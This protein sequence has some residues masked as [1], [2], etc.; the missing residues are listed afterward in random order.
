ML[1]LPY[2]INSRGDTVFY[3]DKKYHNPKLFKQPT[4]LDGTQ[5]TKLNNTLSLLLV[6]TPPHT[7]YKHTLNTLKKLNIK[8]L[9]NY[10]P[11]LEFIN[12]NN[13]TRL[14]FELKAFK[15]KLSLYTTITINYPK[16]TK[17]Q[18]HKKDYNSKINFVIIPKGTTIYKAM[19]YTPYNTNNNRNPRALSSGWFGNLETAKKYAFQANQPLKAKRIEPS[20]PEY[21]RV[22]AFKFTKSAKLFYLMDF[23][24]L[25]TIV[26]KLKS[27]ISTILDR[28]TTQYDTPKHV[29]NLNIS[30]ITKTT[31]NIKIVKML[32]GFQTSYRQQLNLIKDIHP[33]F[34]RKIVQSE[35]Q[36]LNNFFNHEKKN[37]T[38]RV[39]YKIDKNYHS[40]LSYDLN[41]ISMG[42][43]LDRSL[44]KILQKT[45][46]FDG[47]INHRVPSMWE[48]GRYGHNPNSNK[49]PTLDEEI[50]LFVQRG[51][52]KRNRSDPHDDRIFL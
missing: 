46:P 37:R 32:T 48:F 14:T 34:K 1:I 10:Y 19:P 22:Y 39:R 4:Y 8:Q 6:K 27:Q 30:Q 31:E 40:D 16:I 7:S 33:V 50:G 2:K 21:W 12:N 43:E 17:D 51:T 23:N 15:N 38:K 36:I 28:S 11:L 5:Q 29:P 20:S 42:T 41:R 35:V 3:L 24:N 47:Y 44:L 52:I 18:I 26:N 45:Y 25:H 49:I 13:K 9:K